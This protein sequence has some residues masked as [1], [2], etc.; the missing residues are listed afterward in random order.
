MNSHTLALL[1]LAVAIPLSGPESPTRRLAAV[2]DQPRRTRGSR[3]ARTTVR[4]LLS[5]ITGA[6]VTTA[7]GDLDGLLIGLLTGAGAWWLVGRA[8]RRRTTDDPLG[9]AATWDLLAACLRSGLPVA[10]AVAAVVDDLPK[11]AA[12]ALRATAD[13]LT[14][15]ADPVEAWLPAMACPQTAALARG[16][17]R[18]A[19]SGTAL[20]DVATELAATV[21]AVATDAAEATAQRAGVLITAPLGL[22][23]LPAFVC[24]GIA[25]VVAGLAD[26]LSL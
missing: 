21:R 6:L 2:T 17:R 5:G 24:L 7:I 26:Q 15:G 22:C 13:L 25:P 23:F 11:D 4:L 18:T 14:L 20:A 9:L 1:L 19:R 12:Q 3:P 8:T 16:A 10:T